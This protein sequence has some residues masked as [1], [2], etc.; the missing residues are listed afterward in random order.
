MEFAELAKRFSPYLKRLSMKIAIPSRVIEQDDLYQEMLYRLWEGWMRGEF[1]GKNDAYIRGGCYFH[2]KNYLRR[3]T[4]YANII[5]LNE[6]L[7]EDGTTLED[8]IPDQTAPFDVRVDDA[9]F[10]Q[11]MKAKELTRRE[12]DVIE[13]LAQGYTLRDIGKRLNISHVRVLK[14]KENIGSKFTKRLKG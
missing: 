4:E 11:Q 3:H 8:I 5:S 9:L 13:L 10:I 1:E 7:N 12:Q 6:P 2:L 14:I